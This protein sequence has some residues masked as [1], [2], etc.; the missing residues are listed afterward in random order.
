M[1]IVLILAGLI[2]ALLSGAA[3]PIA[4]NV[5]GDI[6]NLFIDQQVSRDIVSSNSLFPCPLAPSVS[7]S[8]ITGQIVNCTAS[9]T[10]SVCTFNISDF[11]PDTVSCINDTDFI[12]AINIQ[13]YIFIGIA[14][15]SFIFSW[16][17]AWF[18]QMAAERQ[19]HRI[20]LKYYRAVLRQDIGWFE[21]HSSGEITARLSGYS[22]FI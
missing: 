6:T 2:A 5:F 1:D 16:L 21:D 15:G 22:N 18:F 11:F 10:I 20:R 14:V 4:M 19:T 7:I 13:V 9:Y 17:H 8:N 3:F 12:A